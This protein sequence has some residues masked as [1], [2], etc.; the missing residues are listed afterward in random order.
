MIQPRLYKGIE[1]VRLDELPAELRENILQVVDNEL[2][3]KILV[4]GKVEDNCLLFDDYLQCVK[5]LNASGHLA[6]Y[7]VR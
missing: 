4:D 5:S 6:G 3:M 7:A 1:Y 2:L